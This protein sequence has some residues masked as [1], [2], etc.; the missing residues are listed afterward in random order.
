M[1]ACDLPYLL[2]LHSLTHLILESDSMDSS[3]TT[4]AG[5]FHLSLH[6][7]VGDRRICSRSSA[8]QTLTPHRSHIFMSQL[9]AKAQA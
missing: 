1:I 6:T 3:G 7:K 4:G 5:T 2:A 8:W 9:L